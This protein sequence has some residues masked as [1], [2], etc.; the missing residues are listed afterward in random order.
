MQQNQ[1]LQVLMERC[2]QYFEQHS[3]SVPRIDRYKYLWKKK[4]DAIHG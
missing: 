3:F 4:I 2:V 1:M